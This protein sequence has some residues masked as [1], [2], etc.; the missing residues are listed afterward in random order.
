[1][2]KVLNIGSINIDYVYRV[3][4]FV[5][6]GETISSSS[7]KRYPGGKGLNQSI[8]MAKAGATV[9]HAGRTGSD[10]ADIVAELRAVAVNT[11]FVDETATVSGHAIIQVDEQ[12]QNCILLHKGANHELSRSYIDSVL[13]AFDSG[14]V[15]VL[16]NEINDLA[17]IMQAAHDKGLWIAFNP[18]PFATEIL[19]LPLSYI[20]CF[21]IN[22]L[23]GQALSG[24]HEAD[25]IIES[26]MVKYPEAAIVLTRGQD[27]VIYQNK[28]EILR[29]GIYPVAVV[30]TTAAGDTF[31]GYFIAGL[32]AGDLPREALRM[33]SIASSITVSREGAAVSIPY[34]DEVLHSAAS[35]S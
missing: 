35:L 29:H 32:L 7:M 13:A 23:E 27:G 31:T 16:Q 14:D 33:A 18:S 25:A 6:A 8:A 28:G 11:D 20:N 15:L 2:A 30:D 19:D 3:E 22:E 12:G 9:Y 17:Y 10:A 1:M 5:R 4:H 26:L 21:F 24:E 34:L